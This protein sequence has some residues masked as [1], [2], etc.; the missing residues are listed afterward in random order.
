MRS[1]VRRCLT[2]IVMIGMCVAANAQSRPAVIE[3]FTSEGCSSCPP[4]ETLVGA[5]AGREN[6]LALSY[7]VDYWDDLGWRDHFA[8]SSSAL[9][10]RAYSGAGA[11]S[12]VYTPEVIV[13]G[14]EDFLGSDRKGIETAIGGVRTGIPVNVSVG[15]GEVLVAL[16]G[17]EC[18]ATSDVLVVTY[19]RKAVASI[20]RGENAGRTLEESNIVR[21]LQTIGRW[22]GI[23][24]SFHV[25]LSSLPRDATDLAVLVQTPGPKQIIGAAS[26]AL[27]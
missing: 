7:H 8:L 11:R 10:Q 26:R 15:E 14:R 21:S 16:G 17:A 4:A 24:E 18:L 5:L 9:R 3:L 27:R 25:P 13:D 2:P 23:A 12:T 22:S 20:A 6:V 19:L 1:L